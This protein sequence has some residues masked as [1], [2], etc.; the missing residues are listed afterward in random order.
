[1]T[2]FGD[3]SCCLSDISTVRVH[4]R[5]NRFSDSSII[6]LSARAAHAEPRP[7]SHGMD[8]AH[9]STVS[10]SLG[11]GSPNGSE[12]YLTIPNA[13]KDEFS[14]ENRIHNSNK[15]KSPSPSTCYK[16][17]V[18]TRVQIQQLLAD[19]GGFTV[20]DNDTLTGKNQAARHHQ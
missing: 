2:V 1:M 9:I 7:A 12:I 17:L 3:Y 4:S 14:H 15:K 10:V 8:Y 16:S 20:H 18:E 5:L 11:F 13:G 6:H 19:G